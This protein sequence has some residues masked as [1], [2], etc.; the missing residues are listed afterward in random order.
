MAG[1]GSSPRSTPDGPHPAAF[2]LLTHA[3]SFDEAPAA[4]ALGP[5]ATA[6]AAEL[7]AH[8][9]ATVYASD[10]PVFTEHPGGRPPTCWQRLIEA[11]TARRR[12]VRADLRLA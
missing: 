1:P 7:R 2:E 4:I 6:A 8:G 12:P 3:R 10:D 9:A 11:E 5:G